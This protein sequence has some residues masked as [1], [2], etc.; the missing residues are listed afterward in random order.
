VSSVS[1]IQK[2]VAKAWDAFLLRDA[3]E[4]V[5]VRSLAQREHIARHYRAA[6]R[7]LRTADR[8]DEPDDAF[9]AL[10]LYR[11]CSILLVAALVKIREAGLT[12]DLSP[13]GAWRDLQST[14]PTESI[15]MADHWA[16]LQKLLVGGEPMALDALDPEELRS[17]REGARAAV[18]RLGAFVDPRSLAEVRVTRYVRVGIAAVVVALGLFLIV[19][20]VA[21]PRD[22]AFYK[23]AIA[24]SQ[25]PGSPLAAGIDNGKIEASYGVHTQ[26]EEW[27][28]V[29]IDL[30]SVQTIHE[31][32]VYNRGD[33]YFDEGLPL[34]LQFS[35]DGKLWIE[36]A[37]RTTPY[38]QADPWVARVGGSRARYLRVQIPRHG[39]VALS[40]IEV[41]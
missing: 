37:R 32:R 13:A 39:Y 9:A 20:W 38:T 21:A 14:L 3:E 6:R 22:L 10:I 11:Q 26:V 40:E 35:S 25:W 33:G 2:S 4:A 15:V 28:W 1:E 29:M 17:F 18:A 5:A 31:V 16:V 12:P 36:I 23:P 27:P 24:S 8:L 30:G 41:F 34:L 7:L 19:H